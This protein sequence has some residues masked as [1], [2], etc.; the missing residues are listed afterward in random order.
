MII[1]KVKY[2]KIR[3]AALIAALFFFSFYSLNAQ[4]LNPVKRFLGFHFDFHATLQDKNIGRTFDPAVIEEFLATVNPDFIQVDTK[5]HKGIASYP[6]DAGYDAGSFDKDVL[7]LFREITSRHGVGLYAHFTGIMDEEAVKRNPSWARVQADGSPDP[8]RVSVFSDYNERI[9]IPQLKELAG[10]YNLDGVWMDGDIWALEP[11]YSPEAVRL[12]TQETG[13]TQIPRDKSDKNYMRFVDFNRRHYKNFFRDYVN[14]LHSYDSDFKITNNWAY[15]SFMP[16]PPEI[17]IDFLSGDLSSTNWISNAAFESRCLSSYGMPWDLMTWSFSN[18]GTKPVNLLMLEASEVI[19][20]GG[21]FQTYWIQNR[22]GS[23]NPAYFSTMKQIAD[24]CRAREQFTYN[25]R[26]IPQVGVYFSLEAWKRKTGSVYNFSGS[27]AA[28]GIVTMLLDGGNAVSIV[29]EH[30][31]A[32]QINNHPVIVVPEWE[33]ISTENKNILLNYARM[34]GKLLLMGSETVKGFEGELGVSL[35][36]E[37]VFSEFFISLGNRPERFELPVQQ[38]DVN[39]A[40]VVI[41]SQGSSFPLATVNDYGRGKIAAIYYDA[42]EKY[43]LE[44]NTA[45]SSVADS[46]INVL[47]P[48]PLV[49]LTS[50]V[51]MH[52]VVSA[53]NDRQ[54]IHLINVNGLRYREAAEYYNNLQPVQN[55]SLRLRSSFRPSAII[56]QPENTPLSFEYNNGFIDISVPQVSIYS[57]LEIQP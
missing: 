49:K 16:E 12:F 34:G 2:K 21:G 48:D 51:K 26:V 8:L 30:Q 52:I 35:E 17:G 25:S 40:K 10:R 50:S 39:T 22:D 36:G 29:M 53:K 19:A 15:S 11:D 20:M 43:H 27:E 38:A 31:L 46:V 5:G 47:Y 14:S 13:I 6:T 32:E 41:N 7:M 3:F 42:G 44:E 55:V 23:I 37:N 1:E 54:H 57:I 56:Q 33:Y 18:K 24:F 28:S 4:P 9:L 45:L